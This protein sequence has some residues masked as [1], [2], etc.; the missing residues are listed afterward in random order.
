MPAE[1]VSS[2]I[3]AGIWGVSTRTARNYFRCDLKG[4]PLHGIPLGVRWSRGPGGNGGKVMVG[5]RDRVEELAQALR[6]AEEAAAAPPALPEPSPASAP[7]PS[8]R[9]AALPARIPCAPPAQG[10]SPRTVAA[11]LPALADKGW[12]TSRAHERYQIIRPI[13]QC[14]PGSPERAKAVDA[15]ARSAGCSSRTVRRW[16]AG[17]EREDLAGLLPA[18]R[19]NRGRPGVFISRA[20]DAA[21][22]FDDEVKAS[23]RAWA[24]ELSGSIYAESSDWGWRRIVRAVSAELA[25]KTSE[26]GFNP[27]TRQLKRLCKVSRGLVER[28]APRRH[29]DT[30]ENDHKRW[31]DESMPRILR[32]REDWRPMKAVIGDVKVMDIHRRRV[33]GSPCTAKL[34]GW[35]DWG[36][37]RICGSVI[38]PRKGEGI[39]QEHVIESF[40]EMVSDPRWGM[41]E[42]LYLDNGGEYNWS[43]FVD[44]AMQLCKVRYLDDDDA[45]ASRFR[46]RPSAVIKALPYNAAAKAI[47]GAFAALD[48]GVFST[49]P[50]YIGGNRMRKKTANVGRAPEPNPLDDEAFARRVA[51]GLAW[52]NRQPQEGFLRGRSPDEAFAAA[53]VDDGWTRTDIDPDVLRVVFSRPATRTL[54]QGRFRLAGAI[55]TAEALWSVPARSKVEVRVPLYGPMDRLAVLDES[56]GFLCMAEADTAYDALDPR[57]AREAARRRRVATSAMKTLRQETPHVDMEA[58]M[59]P[60]VSEAEANPIPERGALVGMGETLEEIAREA[61]RTP[62]ERKSFESARAVREERRREATRNAQ[63]EFLATRGEPAVCRAAP[64]ESGGMSDDRR[65]AIDALL[66]RR[67]A[68]G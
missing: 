8:D 20:W 22:P 65:R 14:A 64:A 13:L 62:A 54:W 15:A 63:D 23:F 66:Q 67:R 51:E 56:G 44:D 50:G 59:A 10:H 68:N 16:L 48:R 33:D 55:Y 45:V 7:L 34:I 47:E 41:P 42:L 25:K 29:L 46:E 21:V 35:I 37:N 9:G 26:A 19:P 12:R 32:S 31:F 17:Y 4:K 60:S 53:V 11:A 30:F 28:A 38:H 2:S 1:W 27:G 40:I 18:S 52:Y 3:A 6:A 36:T 57:G 49:F 39:R 61:R 24:I 5:A 58:L 43:E